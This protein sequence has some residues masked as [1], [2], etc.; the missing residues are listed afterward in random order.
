MAATEMGATLGVWGCH[1]E[2]GWFPKLEI[3]SFFK[4]AVFGLDMSKLGASTVL[5]ADFFF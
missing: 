4:T 5:H 1:V 3:D 2:W